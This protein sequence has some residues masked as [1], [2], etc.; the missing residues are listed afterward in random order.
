[1]SLL[2]LLGLLSSAD[3]ESL[4]GSAGDFSDDLTS[5]RVSSSIL[6]L[7][8]STAASFSLFWPWT[9][10]PLAVW[11]EAG[12]GLGMVSLAISTL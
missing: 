9:I 5:F 1:V 8:F 6:V 10:I 3:E 4:F 12:F 11:L 2:A 7:F